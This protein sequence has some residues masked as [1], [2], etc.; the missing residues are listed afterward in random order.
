MYKRQ[1]GVYYNPTLNINGKRVRFG[2]ST[3]IT[4]LLTDPALQCMGKQLSLIHI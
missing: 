2:D 4:Y 3:Y 1:Q